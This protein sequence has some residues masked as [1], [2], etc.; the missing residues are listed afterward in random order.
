MYIRRIA[1]RNWRS[2]GDVEFRFRQP[3][4]ERKLVLVGAMNGG[5]KTSLL[6]GLYLGLFGRHGLRF[7]EGLG[8]DEDAGHYRGEVAKFRRL[9]ADPWEPS[10]VDVEFCPVGDERHPSV[11]L[12]RRWHFTDR[13]DLRQGDC[14]EVQL[15]VD[16][17]LR[18]PAGSLSEGDEPWRGKLE[19]LL[20]PSRFLPAFF[21]DGEQAQRMIFEGNDRFQKEV[22]VL[23]GTRTVEETAD[24]LRKY[25]G[26]TASEAGGKRKK[27]ERERQR[28]EAVGERERAEE[29]CRQAEAELRKLYEE[30]DELNRQQEAATEELARH[31][32]NR[33][34]DL[35][36]LERLRH[37]AEQECGQ[38]RAELVEQTARLGLALAAHRWAPALGNRLDGEQVRE[39]WEGVKT[40]TEQQTERVLAVAMPEPPEDDPLL[41]FLSASAREQLRE[42][43]REAIQ[44]IYN[45]PPEG[46]PEA[47]L[48]GFATGDARQRLR[49]T[50]DR[51]I[52]A[53]P[54]AVKSATERVLRAEEQLLD[55]ER[56]VRNA[57][58]L[59]PQVDDLR[60]RLNKL[61]ESR[62]EV[63]RAITGQEQER[64]QARGEAEG[65]THRIS[66][67]DAEISR[68]DPQ[69]RR[70]QVAEAAAGALKLLC[71]ELEPLARSTLRSLVERHFLRIADRRFEDHELV[72]SGSVPVLR[73]GDISRPI[74]GM[75][76]F[77]RRAFGIAYSLALVETTGRRFP[78]VIDTPLGNADS[79]YRE[80]LLRA[81]TD[82]D[83]DQVI[84]L[85]HDAEVPASMLRQLEDQVLETFL[86]EYDPHDRVSR[87]K[88][89]CYFGRNRKSDDH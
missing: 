39:Q 63:N 22:A 46:C 43:L 32:G 9:A 60:G 67:L 2:Y 59:P 48:I 56:E 71:D 5:G 55:C 52:T 84:I 18:Q 27:T 41:S 72:F 8:A 50:L 58:D 31:G 78:L 81:L 53:G 74:S 7:V 38:A 49:D 73:Q 20:F 3:T 70:V 33:A 51:W 16:G 4:P 62:D 80:R 86:V 85:P 61:R 42:R 47:Y 76:G 35:S 68:L 66:E 89:D 77:E 37:A 23:Y 26:K 83:L 69:Y 64:D 24:H 65:L 19:S 45:P 1:L 13:G 25:A 17:Q 36:E 21:F 30:R 44:E 57:K 6:I 79:E 10:V 15:Y 28:A 88:P 54:A 75:S 87:V 12:Q 11:R 82:V 29:R 14:E 40:Q 34:G